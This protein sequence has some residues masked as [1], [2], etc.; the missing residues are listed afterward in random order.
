[1]HRA[2]SEYWSSSHI[3]VLAAA[4]ADF[5]PDHY[6]ESKIKKKSGQGLALNLVRTNDILAEI[7]SLGQKPFLVG[8]A[9]ESD[10]VEI[11]AL[12]KLRKK[13]CD[14]LCANDIREPGAGF[15]V[16]TNRITI[17]DCDGNAIPLP[18]LSKREAAKRIINEIAKRVK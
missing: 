4:V 18:M 8:F 5:T 2:S 13:H 3:A 14:M 10:D 1:M 17:Y 15:A 12:V 16:D 7:G 6:A 9:A 11:N